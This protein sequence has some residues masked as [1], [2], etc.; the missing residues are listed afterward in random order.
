MQDLED[1]K[2]VLRSGHGAYLCKAQVPWLRTDSGLSQFDDRVGIARR[3]LAS[4]A[5][6]AVGWFTSELGSD[7]F[8]AEGQVVGGLDQPSVLR[9]VALKSELAVTQRLVGGQVISK[10]SSTPKLAILHA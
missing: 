7:T 5:R 1:G 6:V 8:V 2:S 3:R 10:S 9:C 4:E